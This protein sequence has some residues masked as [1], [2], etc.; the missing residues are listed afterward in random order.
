M[1]A[2]RVEG[3]PIG[4]LLVGGSCSTD[5][6][7]PWQPC[8]TPGRN[9]SAHR[10]LSSW[11][12]RFA[13]R[14]GDLSR[15]RVDRR[16]WHA[17]SASTCSSACRVDHPRVRLPV[18]GEPTHRLVERPSATADHDASSTSSSL[19]LS[20]P[21][22]DGNTLGRALP[23]STRCGCGPYVRQISAPMRTGCAMEAGGGVSRGRARRGRGRRGRRRGCP[24]WRP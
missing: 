24:A 9:W 22:C 23:R 11:A 8:S 20:T 5:Q 15:A 12:P 19:A 7:L 14:P 16:P 2:G 3:S 4:G 18:V 10:S 13:D 6:R 17:L 1:S 21:P